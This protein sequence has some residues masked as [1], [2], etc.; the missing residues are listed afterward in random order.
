MGNG[1]GNGKKQLT[2]EEADQIYSVKNKYWAIRKS[3]NNVILSMNGPI[4]GKSGSEIYKNFLKLSQNPAHYEVWMLV[5]DSKVRE[6]VP[7][8]LL[9]LC[10]T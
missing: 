10:K 9:A 4:K 3:I 7:E 6:S 2:D 8:K 5:E 1:N